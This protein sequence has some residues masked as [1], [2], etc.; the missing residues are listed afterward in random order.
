MRREL[1]RDAA[2]RV[3][4]GNGR[5]RDLG[6]DARGCVGRTLDRQR[7]F[8]GG[9]AVKQTREPLPPEGLAPPTPSSSTTRTTESAASVAVTRAVEALAYFATFV[10]ASAVTEYAAL[11]RGR[12]ALLESLDADRNWSTAG[13]CFDGRG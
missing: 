7:A 3:A 9:D 1:A 10:S 8:E 11:H 6:A 12:V 4:A 2:E 13:E 5:E